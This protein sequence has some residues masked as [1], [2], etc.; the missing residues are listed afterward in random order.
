ML[1]CERFKLY[2]CIID[3]IKPKNVLEIGTGY[4]SF[5]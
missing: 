2:L 5:A 4:G 3:I 1:S